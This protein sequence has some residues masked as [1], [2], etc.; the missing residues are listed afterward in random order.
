MAVAAPLATLD[1]RGTRR[2][3]RVRMVDGT[4]AIVDRAPAALVD[5]SVIGAQVISPSVLRSN[6]RVRL[7][8]SDDAGVLRLKAAI[9]WA[10]FE[11]S[12]ETPRYRAG[13]EF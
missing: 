11:I 1:Y 2:A 3:P 8:L 5:L 4:E 6:Q 9:A 13:I 7:T 10:S 12:K